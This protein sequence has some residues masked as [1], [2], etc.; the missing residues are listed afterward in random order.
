MELAVSTKLERGEFLRLPLM[1]SGSHIVK[2]SQFAG[3]THPNQPRMK[4][5]SKAEGRP[6]SHQH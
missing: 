6:S 5:K 1:N 2:Q 3:Q 4:L